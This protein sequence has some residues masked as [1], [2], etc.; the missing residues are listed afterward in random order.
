MR[1]LDS[2]EERF[3]GRKRKRQEHGYFC[4]AKTRRLTEAPGAFAGSGLKGV[5]RFE[6]R[7][8]PMSWTLIVFSHGPSSIAAAWRLASTPKWSSTSMWGLRQ[9][10]VPVLYPRTFQARERA[11]KLATGADH[12]RKQGGVQITSSVGRRNG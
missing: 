1:S 2:V 6:A 8:A 12:I 11:P 7:P 3:E 9:G 5:A 10:Q 4:V